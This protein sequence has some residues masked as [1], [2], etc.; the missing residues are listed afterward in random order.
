MT[1]QT[2]ESIG[3]AIGRKIGRATPRPLVRPLLAVAKSLCPGQYQRA[4]RTVEA[5]RCSDGGDA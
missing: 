2:A 1:T 4:V 5:E 3:A